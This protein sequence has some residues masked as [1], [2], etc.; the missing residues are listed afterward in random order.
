MSY[1][2]DCQSSGSGRLR[3][4]EMSY[5]CGETANSSFRHVSLRLCFMRQVL[6]WNYCCQ[7]KLFDFRLN[8]LSPVQSVWLSN[9]FIVGS[10][11]LTFDQ[12]FRGQVKMFEFRSKLL[13]YCQFKLFDVRLNVLLPVQTVR[14]SI[15]RIA[16]SASNPCSFLETRVQEAGAAESLEIGKSETGASNKSGRCGMRSIKEKWYEG[17]VSLCW[18]LV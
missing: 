10:N 2:S 12:M 6:P 1:S 18:V 13:V 7:F 11:C 3:L 15:K 17:V 5:V 4:R 9:K 14:L 8:L 16:L